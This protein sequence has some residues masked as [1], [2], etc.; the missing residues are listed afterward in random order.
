MEFYVIITILLFISI[1]LAFRSLR[2]VM[3]LK[4]V[5]TVKRELHKGKILFKSDTYSS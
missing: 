4:E 2:H 1:A 5:G 3:H